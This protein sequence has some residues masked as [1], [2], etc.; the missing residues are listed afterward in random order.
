MRNVSDSIVDVEIGGLTVDTTRF[1]KTT[2]TVNHLFYCELFLDMYWNRPINIVRIVHYDVDEHFLDFLAVT[3]HN[4]KK[5]Q[6]K[7]GFTLL[8]LFHNVVI[9]D[10]FLIKFIRR[11]YVCF[12]LTMMVV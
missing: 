1:N 5:I 7:L 8:E 11:V 6:A 3:S 9:E 10:G 4:F 2:K 12:D